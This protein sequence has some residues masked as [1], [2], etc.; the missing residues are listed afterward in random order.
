MTYQQLLD[1]LMQVYDRNYR[2]VSD[3]ISKM[4]G[5]YNSVVLLKNAEFCRNPQLR[6]FIEDKEG[7]YQELS[8]VVRKTNELFIAQKPPIKELPRDRK[9]LESYVGDIIGELFKTAK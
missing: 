1:N 5:Y 3:L 6:H 4:Q 9:Q 7:R 8:D 2:E